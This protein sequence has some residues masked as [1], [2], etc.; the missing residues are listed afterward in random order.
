MIML[1]QCL[2]SWPAL[3]HCLAFLS[4]SFN[5]FC[6]LDLPATQKKVFLS[7][8]LPYWR[9]VFASKPS[10]MLLKKVFKWSWMDPSFSINCSWRDIE[11]EI[12]STQVE[13]WM[14][15]SFLEEKPS[16]WDVSSEAQFIFRKW[17]NH[18]WSSQQ[19]FIKNPS[20]R[21]FEESLFS[22]GNNR[23]NL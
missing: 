5:E 3:C 6:M 22:N 8:S 4:P 13:N 17:W 23:A 7:R 16:I 19:S 20:L 18:N 2:S 9:W 21:V 1:D 11:A 12:H 14:Y 10:W 15:L